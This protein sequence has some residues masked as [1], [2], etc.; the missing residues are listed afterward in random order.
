MERVECAGIGMP[1]VARS[2]LDS[3]SDDEGEDTNERGDEGW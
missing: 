1:I 2:M 3:H